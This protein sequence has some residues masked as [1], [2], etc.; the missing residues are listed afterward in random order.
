MANWQEARLIPVTGISSDKEAEQRATSALLA[1][2]S[3][4][5]PFS[6]SL[7]S[8][9]GASKADR[10][11]V[12]CYV[13]PTFKDAA[14][15]SIRPDGLIRVS[16]GTKPPWIALV[17]V[18][19]GTS[20]LNADQLNAYWDIARVNGFDAVLSIS[21]E[22]APS[23][24]IHP[25]PG[26]K[27]RSNSK[28]G[29]HHLSWTRLL[30]TAVVEKTHRGVDDPEQDW[31]LGEL[32]RYLEHDA[33][34]AM[35]FEDMGPAWV[36][37]RDGARDGTLNTRDDSVAEIAQRWD[38]L[39][40]YVSLKLGSEIGEDVVELV[41]RAQ[42]ND[43]TLRTKYFVESMASSALLDGKLR[44]PNT[45]GD[46]D[47]LVD[48]KARQIETSASFA[49]PSDKQA[50][51]RVT[52]LLRQLKDCP[53]S[54]VVEAYP[55]NSSN[56]SAAALGSLRDDPAIII[57]DPKKPVSRFRLVARTEMGMNRKSGK[58]AG[59]TQ[60]VYD[61]VA[62]FYGTILQDLTAYQAPAPKRVPPPPGV[63]EAGPD[64]PDVELVEPAA[65]PK[66][67]AIPMPAVS[68]STSLQGGSGQGYGVR[69]P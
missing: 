5:R 54:L 56:G 45:I 63:D 47:I 61:C 60:S 52:W 59:F 58:K 35:G 25:T 16:H 66:R 41:P 48:I 17:E 69:R 13:E 11:I 20:V 21:N 15:R 26:L 42:Q 33:S 62:N 29:V 51:A 38:Q 68:W 53:D 24:G 2:V 39:L 30:T 3:I 49:A 57:D 65:S 14:G 7:L 64:L 18:K 19:T 4:V 44:I 9:Y 27:V 55:K 28:V 67:T 36:G 40:G 43:P 46:I 12:E 22:I 37:V 50:K 32:I 8:A 6:K 31:I 34:G 23:P 1:V 10:A